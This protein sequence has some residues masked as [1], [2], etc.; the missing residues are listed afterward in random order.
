M[1]VDEA[2]DKS[3]WQAYPKE[4]RTKRGAAED[5]FVQIVNGRHKRRRG[6]AQELVDGAR[7]YATSPR[8]LREYI[9]NPTTWLNAG[10]WTDEVSTAGTDEATIQQEVNE[11]ANSETGRAVLNANGPVEG[12]RRLREFAMRKR[13]GEEVH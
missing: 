3:F 9:L 12:M 6:T 7:R 11:L 8:V 10:S 2:F 4:G 5:L 1:L 13:D